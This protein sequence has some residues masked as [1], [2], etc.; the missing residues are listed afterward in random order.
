MKKVYF[1]ASCSTCQRIMKDVGVDDSWIQQ[2]I[3]AK[4]ITPKQITEMKKLAGSY[5]SLFSRTAMKYREMNLREKVLTEKDYRT[6]ILEYDTFLKRPDFIIDD[7]IFIGN[8][9]KTVQAII[10]Y[11]KK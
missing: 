8:A 4:K 10:D 6:L 7:Q 2:N 11:L 5:E 3:R 9:K 1:L